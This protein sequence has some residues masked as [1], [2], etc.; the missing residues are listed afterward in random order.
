LRQLERTLKDED[1]MAEQIV[2]SHGRT[3]ILHANE[4]ATA[5]DAMGDPEGAAR[6]RRI[7]D[8]I[9]TQAPAKPEGRFG[10]GA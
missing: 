4:T 3:A 9:L 8:I 5:L 6:W 1:G 2:C 10:R 7:R